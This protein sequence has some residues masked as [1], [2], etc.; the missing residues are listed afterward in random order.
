MKHKKLQN[1]LTKNNFSIF[2]NQF[3]FVYSNLK[4]MTKSITISFNESD[5]NT[6]MAIFQKFDVK[7]KSAKKTEEEIIR[8]RLSD[9]Y[10]VDGAWNKMS[11]EEREDAAHAETLIYRKEMGDMFLS[12]AQAQSFLE[13]LEKTN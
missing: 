7:I 9:K 13:E 8:Q 2:T 5:E 12:K 10:F 1:R 4:S 6:L 3:N 11:S